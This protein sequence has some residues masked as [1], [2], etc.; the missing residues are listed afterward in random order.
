MNGCF[1]IMKITPGGSGDT[2]KYFENLFVKEEKRTINKL[3]IP[4][5]KE[6]KGGDYDW[7]YGFEKNGK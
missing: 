2:K 4:F 1:W 3:E 7:M 6:P 5:N